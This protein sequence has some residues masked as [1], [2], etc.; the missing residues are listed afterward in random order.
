MD[1]NQNLGNLSNRIWYVY[2]QLVSC[3]TEKFLSY[4]EK[5]CAYGKGVYFSAI[6]R[7]CANLGREILK[8][9]IP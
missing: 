9:K 4:L 3:K 7:I 2:N 8:G 6:S 5:A 1:L